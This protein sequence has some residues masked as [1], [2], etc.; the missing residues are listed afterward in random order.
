MVAVVWFLRVAF[1]VVT[2]TR[3]ISARRW[4]TSIEEDFTLS[5][6]TKSIKNRLKTSILGAIAY[7]NENHNAIGMS[8]KQ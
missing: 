4:M 7:E 8:W 2:V 3:L 5:K 1:R 6:T